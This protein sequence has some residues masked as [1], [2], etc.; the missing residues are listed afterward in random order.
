MIKGKKYGPYY[1]KSYREGG[2]VK[3]LYISPEELKSSNL[4]N[5]GRVKSLVLS[6]LILIVLLVTFIF[7]TTLELEGKISLDVQASYS[8]GEK[9]FGGIN[10]TISEGELIPAGSKLSAVIGNQSAEILL[11]EIASANIIDGDYYADGANLIGSGSGYGLIGE[12]ES[13][14]EVSFELLVF[15]EYDSTIN[16]SVSGSVSKGNDFVYSLGENKTAEIVAGSIKVNEDTIGDDL[17]SLQIEGNEARVSTSYS[18]IEE[19]F[20]E[21]FLGCDFIVLNID[22]NA[23]NLTAENG[24]LSIDLSYNEEVIASALAE[25]VVDDALEENVTNQTSEGNQTAGNQTSDNQQQ[26][27]ITTWNIS[28]LKNIPAINVSKNGNYSLNLSEYFKGASSYSFTG[29]NASATFA[30]KIAVIKPANNFVG[31]AKGKITAHNGTASKESN[32]FL[33]IVLAPQ[34]RIS[35]SRESIIKVGQPVKWVTNITLDAPDIINI[36]LPGGADNIVVKKI[37]GNVEQIARAQI[38]PVTLNTIVTN[39][40]MEI[41]LRK[42]PKVVQWMSILRAKIKKLITGKAV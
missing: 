18:I 14:P 8:P 31:T 15:D 17:V 1:Y 21:E 42:E 11:S 2:R 20:G 32:E 24:T 28:L 40:C 13:Y 26:A 19:G 36:T 33:I 37:E 12:K 9:I 23:L 29:A 35:T 41:E 10:I 25:I 5:F 7:I 6:L 4:I 30:N 22:L 38:V 34:L 16:S 27:N 39:V 3:K